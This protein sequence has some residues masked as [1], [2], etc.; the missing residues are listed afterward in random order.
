M[1][2]PCKGIGVF[3]LSVNFI[4]KPRDDGR[5]LDPQNG[6][7]VLLWGVSLTVFAV[8]FRHVRKYFADPVIRLFTA[9]FLLALLSSAFSASP[10]ISLSTSLGILSYIA[11]ATLLV[12]FVEFTSILRTLLLALTLYILCN[13]LAPF[14]VPDVAYMVIDPSTG[15]LRYRGISGQPNTLA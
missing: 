7:K 12:E 9:L 1:R 8:N 11:L 13:L 3:V 2:S 4:D 6:L 14:V 15:E 10:A 5:V